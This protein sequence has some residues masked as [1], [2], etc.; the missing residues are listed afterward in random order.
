MKKIVR[1]AGMTMVATIAAA[2]L[3]VATAPA[4]NA[5]ADTGWGCGG[6]CRVVNR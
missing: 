4:S 6:S 1:R 3:V 2:G 5:G